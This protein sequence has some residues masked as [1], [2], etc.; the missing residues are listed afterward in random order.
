LK[1]KGWA[2]WLIEAELTL[3][4]ADLEYRQERDPALGMALGSDYGADILGFFAITADHFIARFRD[5]R[6][7]CEP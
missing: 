7:V 3:S 5:T 1:D 6:C 4:G 2:V